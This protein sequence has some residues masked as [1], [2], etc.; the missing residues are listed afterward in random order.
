MVLLHI[1]SDN[2]K[3]ASEIADLLVS[4]N[5]VLNTVTLQD[6]SIKQKEID[7][8][9]SDSKQILII[10]R[11]KGILFKTVE[12]TLRDTFP[13]NEPIIYSMPIVNMNWQEADALAVSEADYAEEAI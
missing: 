6:I 13:S 8:K 11:T 10:A 12:K 9:V 5:L 1:I 4:Q 3:Q 2:G 7:G